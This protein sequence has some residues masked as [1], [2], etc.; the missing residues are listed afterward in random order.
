ME[1]WEYLQI[2]SKK[3]KGWLFK[4]D[5]LEE[6][7]IALD[8]IAGL[9]HPTDI[10]YLI[11]Y[12][13]DSK[14]EVQSSTIN[15]I[16]HLFKQIETKKEYY[17][18]LKHCDITE[19][20]IDYYKQNYSLDEYLTLLAISSLNHSGYVREK[21]VRNLINTG[22]ERAI[23]FIV[24]RM[25]DWVNPVRTCALNGVKAFKKTEFIN[26]LVRHLPIF[27]WLQKVERVDLS[28]AFNEIM[29]FIIK[30]NRQYIVANYN[31]FGDKTRLLIAK[32]ISESTNFGLSELSLLLQDKHFLIRN[33]ALNHFDKLNKNELTKLLADHSAR[34]R[35]QTLYK[36]KG[37]NNFSE[38]I[39]PFLFD[40]STSIREFARFSLKNQGLN[41]AFL[42]NNSLLAKRNITA[43]LNGLAETKGLAYVEEVEVFLVSQK[44]KIRKA[45]FA[46]LA[47]LDAKKGYS[48]ALANLETDYVGVRNLIV[49][50]L[51]KQPT[52]EVLQKARE[53][54]INGSFPLKKS[55][56]ML[57][58]KV[59]KWTAIAD[60]M[61][62]TINENETIRQLSFDYLQQWRKKIINNFTQPKVADL[63]RANKIF[64]FVFE[65]H[66]AKKYFRQNP[67][68]G[69]DFLLR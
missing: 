53:I 63:E 41:F 11:S 26:A 30:D 4:S 33:L 54:F 61:L 16:M 25:A 49:E 15:I 38:I 8:Q 36:L 6:R 60:I 43:S 21:A 10:Q 39:Y 64:T 13:K 23:P 5:N 34:V 1:L 69:I 29:D 35:I 12:L 66:E 14:T 32:Q 28:E 56:L 31:T 65:M 40:E 68:T 45:A 50:F 20:D 51:A 52:E 48:F 17:D 62:G 7:L 47:K 9:A 18:A 46:A 58:N 44:P 57:F 42:Y 24:Y 55:M 67:L 37:Q 22:D 59:G 3:E 19:E 2:L 27:A